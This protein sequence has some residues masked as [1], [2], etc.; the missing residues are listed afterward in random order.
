MKKLL[1]FLLPLL[2]FA[3]WKGWDINGVIKPKVGLWDFCYPGNGYSLAVGT[4]ITRFLLSFNGTTSMDTIYIDSI[5]CIFYSSATQDSLDSL[6]IYR[7]ATRTGDESTI[8]V[9]GDNTNRGLNTAGVFSFTII[10]G[11]PIVASPDW[12]LIIA[13]WAK[14]PVTGLYIYTGKMYS[15]YK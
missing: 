8:K 7:G 6:I 11:S 2:L 12:R 4:S 5:R 9:W 3:G 15:H 14:N 10:P 1:I 13:L